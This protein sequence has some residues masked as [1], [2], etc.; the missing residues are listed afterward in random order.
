M[1]IEAQGRGIGCDRSVDQA[2]D[3]LVVGPDRAVL[4]ERLDLAGQRGDGVAVQPGQ[5]DQRQPQGRRGA[6]HGRLV[7]HG[8][9][10]GAVAGEMCDGG[11]SLAERERLVERRVEPG[12]PGLDGRV[13]VEEHVHVLFQSDEYWRDGVVS[14]VWP[15]GSPSGC[16]RPRPQP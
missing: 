12:V 5:L 11:Q 10:P 9:Q 15:A 13:V 8:L 1:G 6:D 7:A 3:K 2:G 4:A 16:V 14:G